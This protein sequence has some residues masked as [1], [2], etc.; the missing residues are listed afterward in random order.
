MQTTAAAASGMI[1]CPRF[2]EKRRWNFTAPP[3]TASCPFCHLERRQ[4]SSFV[5][6]YGIFSVSPR[7]DHDSRRFSALRQPKF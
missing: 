7:K 1:V 2:I 6:H 5:N 4:R 3:L